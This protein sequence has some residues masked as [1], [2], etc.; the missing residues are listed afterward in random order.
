MPRDVEREAQLDKA[1]ALIADG[2]ALRQD[3]HRTEALLKYDH[4]ARIYES[5]G[6]NLATYVL[7]M[8]MRII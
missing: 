4:A 3:G 8:D 2:A 5:L 7:R 1:A 6:N